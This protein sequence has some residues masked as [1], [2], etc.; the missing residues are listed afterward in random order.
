M[1]ERTVTL[2]GMSHI[3]ITC[4]CDSTMAIPFDTCEL[5]TA[6]CPVCDS[7]LETAAK[8]VKAFKEFFA[9]ATKF[10]EE[11]NGYVEFRTEE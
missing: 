8:A 1:G 10:M 2:N 3:V 6:K 11:A 5:R 4:K 7:D 9:H